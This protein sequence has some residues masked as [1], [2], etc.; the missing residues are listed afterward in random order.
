MP[1]IPQI[2]NLNMENIDALR[3]IKG[4][5]VVLAKKKPVEIPSCFI[6]CNSSTS[7]GTNC[8]E[9]DDLY[10]VLDTR[11][12]HSFCSINISSNYSDFDVDM[13]V[14][15]SEEG[16]RWDVLGR[17]FEIIYDD[18]LTN[19]SIKRDDYF[20]S[21]DDM[22]TW[23]IT[24]ITNLSEPFSS[25][26]SWL[27]DED[28]LVTPYG[29]HNT[30][31]NYTERKKMTKSCTEHNTLRGFTACSEIHGPFSKNWFN[32]GAVKK[33][34]RLHETNGLTNPMSTYNL[35]VDLWAMGNAWR[36]D[37]DAKIVVVGNN[38]TLY[39]A[40]VAEGDSCNYPFSYYTDPFLGVS[41]ANL[42]MSHEIEP[43][44]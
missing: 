26:Y 14:S 1:P 29:W 37:N 32:V 24:P 40:V 34:V 44:F 41:G 16:E 43:K 30:D 27:S 22:K 5:S 17:D 2:I 35:Q 3:E 18:N 28:A 13:E 25:R 21:T 23:I 11:S 9:K 8:C 6:C 7:D 4:S 33:N 42:Q 19:T 20:Y 31:E 36:N 38:K 39:D 15:L 12:V 10:F